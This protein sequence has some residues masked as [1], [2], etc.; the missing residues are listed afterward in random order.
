VNDI[1]DLSK[2]EAQ[3]LVLENIGFDLVETV[4]AT[5]EI[6]AHKAAE[7]GIELLSEIDPRINPARTGDPTRLRQIM[8]N[9]ISNALKF[10]ERGEIVVRV[11]QD[12]AISGG[13][14]LHFAVSDTGI[15]IPKAKLE[16]IFESFT[17]VDSSTTRKYGGT[18]LGLTISRSLAR[19]MGGEIWVESEEGRGSVF[20]FTV[21]LTVAEKSL[22]AAAASGLDGKRI[23]VVDDNATNR[24]IVRKQLT[25]RGAQVDEAEGVEAALAKIAGQPDASPYDLL[26]VDCQMPGRDGFDL[27]ETLNAGRRQ[28]HA[29]MMLSS[30]DLNSNMSRARELGIA[31]YLIKPVK[32]KDLVQRVG[33]LL[34]GPAAAGQALSTPAAGGTTVMPLSI[35]LVDD[36]EDNR[37]LIKAYVKNLPYTVIEAENGQI[38]VEKFRQSVYD[39]VLMDVQMPVMDGHEATRTMRAWEQ[40]NGKRPTPIISLTAHAIK[41]EIDKCLAAGCNTHIA[42]PVKKSTLIETLQSL[43]A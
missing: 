15:G 32:Q 43:T 36:N 1:L 16:D 38:A 25:G 33:N 40:N 19:M 4:E 20:H 22:P 39:V 21:N 6:Y 9:L 11:T 42:K 13:G 30:A 17:Q 3:Q 34:A 26:L 7:K 31:E 37:L 23:L 8:L 28:V 41:E 24:L 35:L 12:P 27:V 10:T 18:G 5:V 14:R 2:I 29:V